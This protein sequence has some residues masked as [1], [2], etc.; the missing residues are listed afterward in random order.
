VENRCPILAHEKATLSGIPEVLRSVL[1]FRNTWL[2]LVVRAAWWVRFGE[3][4]DWLDVDD[5]CQSAA[6]PGLY[7]VAALTSFATG[8]VIIAFP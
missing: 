5:L 1:S 2:I 4:R 6:A 3:L 8:C 7:A